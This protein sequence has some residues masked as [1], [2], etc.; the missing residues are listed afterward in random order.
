VKAEQLQFDR[1]QTL[2][3][4]IDGDSLLIY[5]YGKVQANQ[6]FL[7]D[8]RIPYQSLPLPIPAWQKQ[9]QQREEMMKLLVIL[10]FLF[11]FFLLVSVFINYRRQ[12]ALYSLYV[13]PG[14]VVNEMPSSLEPALLSRLRNVSNNNISP[15]VF[16]TLVSLAQ[17]GVI[18]ITAVPKSKWYEAA[19]TLQFQY[20]GTEMELSNMEKL[21]LDKVFCYPPVTEPLKFSAVQRKLY[22]KT[23]SFMK[24]VDEELINSNLV[25]PEI[26]A[27]RKRKLVATLV[28]M[29]VTALFAMS[30]L[31][32]FR[33]GIPGFQQILA[34]GLIL[35]FFSTDY[36]LLSAIFSNSLTE[37]GKAEIAYW[38][39]Y[40]KYLKQQIH[41]PVY[42]PTADECSSIFVYAMALNLGRPWVSF[43]RKNNIPLANSWLQGIDKAANY[44]VPL[45]VIAATSHP[46]SGAHGGNSSAGGGGGF[47]GAG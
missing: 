42:H 3:P 34:A 35:S 37:T 26:M 19:T 9:M 21:V 2:N 12:L 25:D 23:R 40:S 24:A 43:C 45:F 38:H 14:T 20:A 8:M 5:N 47:A 16:I 36:L 44:W 11:P 1:R 39:A 22:Q 32:Q 30:L 29:A 46:S 17:K 27:R 18:T 4:Q 15:L 33:S 41:N 10:I 7:I 13:Q 31:F 6:S 28:M